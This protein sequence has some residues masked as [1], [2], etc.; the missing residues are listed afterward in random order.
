MEELLLTISEYLKSNT[1]KYL[2]NKRFIP[3][4]STVLYSGPYWDE[5][6]ILQAIKTLLNGNWLVAGENVY[7]FERLFAKKFGVKYSHM[8]N[9]GS[10]ANL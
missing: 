9:S 4:K 1:P 7:K 5:N 10:S 8:V 6:E 3:N 2:Y